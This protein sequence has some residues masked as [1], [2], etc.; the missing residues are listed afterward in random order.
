MLALTMDVGII[1]ILAVIRSL[2]NALRRPRGDSMG[3]I[4]FTAGFVR[5]EKNLEDIQKREEAYKFMK[6]SRSPDNT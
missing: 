4:A 6:K 2:E 5:N 1:L 3:G